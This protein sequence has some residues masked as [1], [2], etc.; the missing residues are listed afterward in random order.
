MADFTIA[1]SFDIQ[2]S[3]ED[4]R[5]R[6]TAVERI[7]KGPPP[8]VP[9]S[10]GALQAVQ[11]SISTASLIL[12]IIFSDHFKFLTFFPNMAPASHVSAGI[13]HFITKSEA[14]GCSPPKKSKVGLISIAVQG[15]LRFQLLM[16]KGF[17]Q[18]G[19]PIRMAMARA[20]QM[21]AAHFN[22]TPPRLVSGCFRST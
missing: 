5:D 13:G 18:S 16:F 8:R 6:S 3:P 17:G 20:T 15:S 14:H 10:L 1:R 4:G 11:M 21:G 22:T 7:I 12:L 19:W 9:A 2:H